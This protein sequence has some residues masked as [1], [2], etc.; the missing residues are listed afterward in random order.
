[1]KY[2]DRPQNEHE[3]YRLW[4]Q[5]VPLTDEEIAQQLEADAAALAGD[6]PD[7]FIERLR[8]TAAQ[9]R[10]GVVKGAIVRHAVDAL[11]TKCAVCGGQSLY[12]VGFIEGRC[13]DHRSHPSTSA[14]QRNASSYMLVAHADA[15]RRHRLSMMKLRLVRSRGVRG[16]G[17]TEIALGLSRILKAKR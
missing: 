6:R 13:S 4:R 8:G 9:A 2:D 10:R 5:H 1:M 17:F 16:E 3:W 15:M 7:D 11:I 12:R 14:T